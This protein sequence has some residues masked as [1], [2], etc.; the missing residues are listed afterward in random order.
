MIS[1]SFSLYLF[2]PEVENVGPAILSS[3]EQ[4]P[5]QHDVGV[6]PVASK[7]GLRRCHSGL[8]RL[9]AESTQSKNLQV[10][11]H[12]VFVVCEPALVFIPC[13]FLYRLLFSSLSALFFTICSCLEFQLLPARVVSAVWLVPCLTKH[14]SR[15]RFTK[16]TH[17]SVLTKNQPVL[18]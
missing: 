14:S 2:V 9:I 10:F 11:S 4:L 17:R 3:M 6:P 16:I 13:S 8:Q 1:V 12:I 15:G 5:K 7:R 18:S